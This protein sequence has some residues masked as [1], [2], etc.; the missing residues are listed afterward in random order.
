[1]KTFRKPLL[2]GLLTFLT[3]MLGQAYMVDSVKSK[4]QAKSSTPTIPVLNQNSKPSSVK[5]KSYTL[6]SDTIRVKVNAKGGGVYRTELLNYSNSLNDN[7]PFT[8][9]ERSDNNYYAAETGFTGDNDLHFTQ[10]KPITTSNGV[11]TLVLEAKKQGATYIKTYE[12]GEGSYTLH[13]K[14]TII[15]HGKK[16]LSAQHYARFRGYQD[17]N[18]TKSPIPKPKDYTLD[19]DQPKAGLMSFN[20]YQGPAYYSDENPY[21]KSPFTEFTTKPVNA[22]IKQPGW[23]CIQQRYFLAAWV[24]GEGPRHVKTSWQ[25]GT[26]EDNNELYR[27]IF[28]FDSNRDPTSIAPGAS[29]TE[30][31]KLYAGP[32]IANEL[33][34]LAKGLEYTVDY[35]VLWFISDL[36]FKTLVFIH[37][38][39]GSWGWAI[40]MTTLLIKVLFYKLDESRYRSMAKQKKLAPR[41][42]A[43][44]KQYPDD[45]EK[46]SQATLELYRKENINPLS[47]GCLLSLLQI[48]FF[49]ALYYVL[50]ESV[51]LRHASFLWVPDLSS[52]D[53]F[54]VL[55]LAVGGA[56][57]LTNQLSPKDQDPTQAQMKIAMPI[58]CTAMFAYAPAGL[59]LYWFTNNLLSAVQQWYISRK[60]EK[61]GL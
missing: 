33:A 57:F 24:T 40:V 19:T 43:I 44:Q 58:I 3:I 18:L 26:L 50:I 31:A 16:P 42:E 12:L 6:Q 34:S 56:M 53:P 9:F 11:T 54:F 25:S 2:L 35:G 23:I 8:L 27:Q 37:Q 29:V 10:K 61:E 39:L 20:T 21:V 5:A 46:R 15:N 47:G 52:H 1:M 45:Q 30:E 59:V 49:A 22:T 36:L 17:T 32:E 55:P 14:T 4:G 48:P 13:V 28:Q 7:S 60:Y 38:Y 51:Q 41:I